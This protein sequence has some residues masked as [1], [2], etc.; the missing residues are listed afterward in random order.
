MGIIKGKLWSEIF[1]INSENDIIKKL[2][3]YVIENKLLK[4]AGTLIK[5][6]S[7]KPYPNMKKQIKTQ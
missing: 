7:K 3:R 5:S 2:R 4:K 1:N 6:F